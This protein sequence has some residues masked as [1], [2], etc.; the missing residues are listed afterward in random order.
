MIHN[1]KSLNFVQHFNSVKFDKLNSTQW[2]MIGMLLCEYLGL[3][4]IHLC[5]VY[6]QG[7]RTIN[8]CLNS[9]RYKINH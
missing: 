7:Y 2:W 4:N 6:V 8:L 9:Y 5:L 1:I 3:Q